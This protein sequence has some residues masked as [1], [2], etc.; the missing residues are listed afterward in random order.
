MH[1]TRVL[2]TSSNNTGMKTRLAD[3]VFAYITA[4]RSASI[5]RALHVQTVPLFACG[6]NTAQRSEVPAKLMI[7]CTRFNC[8]P[9]RY[10]GLLDWQVHPQH[11]I[12]QWLRPYLAG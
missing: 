4:N 6:L 7:P 1:Q 8:A 2:K 11:S 5:D 10:N 3:S 12:G 9:P